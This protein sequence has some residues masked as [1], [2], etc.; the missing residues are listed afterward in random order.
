MGIFSFFSKNRKDAQG[1]LPPEGESAEGKAPESSAPAEAEEKPAAAAPQAGQASAD[2]L[3]PGEEA[4]AEDGLA[5]QGPA[6][7]GKG[8]AEDASA[9]EIREQRK[10]ETERKLLEDLD[11][12][13]DDEAAEGDG[14]TFGAIDDWAGQPKDARKDQETPSIGSLDYPEVQEPDVPSD[15]MPQEVQEPYFLE[16][17]EPQEL[18]EPLEPQRPQAPLEPLDPQGLKDPQEPG[19]AHNARDSV[20]PGPQVAQDTV[21][22]EPAEAD[23]SPSAGGALAAEADGAPSTGRASAE[24][25]DGAPF[26][27]GAMTAETEGEPSPGGS[28]ATDSTLDRRKES[29]ERLLKELDDLLG[30]DDVPGPDG[31]EDSEAAQEPAAPAE[32]APGD[33]GAPAPGIP[34]TGEDGLAPKGGLGSA[35]PDDPQAAG[36]PDPSGNGIA[37]EGKKRPPGASPD[38][39]ADGP[40]LAAAAGA[41]R[42]EPVPPPPSEDS[43]MGRLRALLLD[44]E[45]KQISRL[46]GVVHD[47]Q[48]LA[49]AISRVITEALLL[50]SKKDD[51]LLTVLG[52]TV[53]TIVTSSV[54]RNPETIAN[55]IFPVI[56]PAIRRF[57]SD[58]FVSMLQSLNSTLEMSL[59]LKGLK[60]RLEAWR[61]HKPFSEIVLLHTLLYHVEEI[62]LIHA[63]SG[64]I[65]DHIIAEGTE[66]RDAELVAAMFT[67]IRDFVRDSFSV[68]KTEQLDNIRFGERTIY[69]QRT[70]K[71]FM[72]A[73]VRGNPPASLGRDLQD[74]LDLM[75]VN[76]AE[77]LDRF[78]GNPEPFRKN[79]PFFQNFLE[80]RYEDKPRKLPFILRFAP[81][82]AVLL[83]AL[84]LGLRASDASRARAAALEQAQIA[85]DIESKRQNARQSFRAHAERVAARLD[86]A[87]GIVAAGFREFPGTG[88]V[89]RILKDDLAQD[90][91]EI[92]EAINDVNRDS[93]LLEVTPYVST[94]REIIARKVKEF[95]VVPKGV[96]YEFDN[97]TGTL[98]F[99]GQAGLGWIQ[100]TASLALAIPGVNRIDT[101]GVTDPDY[102]KAKELQALINQ[103]VIHFPLGKFEPVA[104]DSELFE[105][106]IRRLGEL[107]DIADRMGVALTLTL[108]GH[109]DQVGNETRNYEISL[110]RAKTVAARLYSIGSRMTVTIY[111]MG[112]QLQS[113]EEEAPEPVPA[114]PKEAAAQAAARAAEERRRA[115]EGDPKSRRLEFR[116]RLG[117]EKDADASASEAEEGAS[118]AMQSE[119]PPQEPDAAPDSQEP[120]AAPGSQEPAAAP[121]SQEP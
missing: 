117:N 114:D 54:R 119:T 88:V 97:D 51:K 70:E 84:F 110:E 37:R 99:S 47:T 11:A 78:S 63:E 65:L 35:R 90:P 115:I 48:A 14:P 25:T 67:A 80:A 95:L 111:N 3:A 56:G 108:Y 30:E 57:I 58:T 62:Y 29:E 113:P 17:Q 41:K 45:M 109:A 64:L 89:V 81:F 82:A 27:G 100:D 121:G 107:E 116:V 120:A 19:E 66:T 76:S 87:P 12:L 112:S 68:G 40:G 4:E 92:L 46:E 42:S 118:Q 91:H 5:W 69:L 43:E 104:E 83:I 101:S 28:L 93:F 77:D 106:T 44:R 72:A 18:L 50:R 33:D 23:G 61:V 15:P 7:G 13:L 49:Q 9:L 102:L 2:A 1:P 39:G 79:R 74:A 71:V 52:P 36:A 26:A 10:R 24:E 16:P 38:S 20:A 103:A 53:E 31:A 60:W 86:S 85:A 98:K 75:A 22:P 32:E 34:A 105:S 59:S 8:E 73:V 55:Q 21:R 96:A 94:D 6:A